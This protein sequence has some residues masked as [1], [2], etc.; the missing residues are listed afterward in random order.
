MV[1]S[2]N[3]MECFLFC[4]RLISIVSRYTRM[5]TRMPAAISN[6][7]LISSFSICCDLG[8]LAIPPCILYLRWQLIMTP[9]PPQVLPRLWECACLLALPSAI[10]GFVGA[11]LDMLQVLIG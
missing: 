7:I 10:L 11:T 2:I 9:M 3:Q 5:N 1:R 8:K 4:V 6:Y